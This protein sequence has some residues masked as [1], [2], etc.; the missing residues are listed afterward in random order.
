[1]KRFLASVARWFGKRLETRRR[2]GWSSYPPRQIETQPEAAFDPFATLRLSRSE[3]SPG[4][5]AEACTR[6]S[7]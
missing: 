5:R 3:P 2:P 1:M 6:D 7:A 4:T